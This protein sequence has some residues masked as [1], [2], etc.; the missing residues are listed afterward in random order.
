MSPQILDENLD[1]RK[2]N[3]YEETKAPHY[4]N[5]KE[6]LFVTVK[7]QCPSAELCENGIMK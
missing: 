4:E 2:N 5:R 7:T 1:I 6:E 3:I